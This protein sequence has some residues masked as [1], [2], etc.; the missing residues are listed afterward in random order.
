MSPY[1]GYL[2]INC[3][4]LIFVIED[5][6]SVVHRKHYKKVKRTIILTIISIFWLAKVNHCGLRP[7]YRQTPTQ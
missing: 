1:L 2:R 4:L 6:I 3:I 5:P 7:E